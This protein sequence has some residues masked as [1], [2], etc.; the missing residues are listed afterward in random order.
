MQFYTTYNCTY[1]CVVKFVFVLSL[2]SHQVFLEV[3]G[4]ATSRSFS[5]VFLNI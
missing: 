4:G 1:C 2:L 3:F 5:L